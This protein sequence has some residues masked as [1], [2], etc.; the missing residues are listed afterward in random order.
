MLFILC[1]SKQIMAFIQAISYTMSFALVF[2]RHL[3]L[4]APSMMLRSSSQT[5]VLRHVEPQDNASCSK[6]ASVYILSGFLVL[7]L[8][9]WTPISY[10]PI[11]SNYRQSF[12]LQDP[13]RKVK[14]K[15]DIFF[16]FPIPIYLAFADIQMK[17]LSLIL[18]L[19][20]VAA[21][22]SLKLTVKQV[23]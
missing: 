7:C 14:P 22:F 4:G 23:L 10:K 9:V 6:I 21:T 12:K 2:H 19:L 5:T 11:K 20:L 8:S 16:F 1:D 17:S 3:S 18:V 15:V 13:L